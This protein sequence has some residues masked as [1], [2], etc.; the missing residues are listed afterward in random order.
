MTCERCGKKILI[1]TSNICCG[2]WLCSSCYDL[3][4]SCDDCD[5]EDTNYDYDDCLGE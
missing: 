3:Y 2:H 1:S 4:N 5:D